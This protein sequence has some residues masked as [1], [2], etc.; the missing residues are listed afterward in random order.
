MRKTP[1]VQMD[2]KLPKPVACLTD[3]EL[4]PQNRKYV[5]KGR[6]KRKQKGGYVDVEKPLEFKPGWT[7]RVDQ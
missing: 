4:D 3:E 6:K 7:Q 2:S 5:K 1:A